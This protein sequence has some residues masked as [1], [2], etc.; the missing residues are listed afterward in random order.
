[1]SQH[2]FQTRDP[3]RAAS[4]GGTLALRREQ[5]AYLAPN[6]AQQ[7]N[8]IKK[9]GKAEAGG[10]PVLDPVSKKKQGRRGRE[11]LSNQRLREESF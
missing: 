9:Q 3:Q 6:D 10:Q 4:L 1:L 2:T 11:F 5:T 7:L 8:Q